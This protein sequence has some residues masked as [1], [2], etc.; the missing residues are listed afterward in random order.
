[1]SI[2]QIELPDEELKFWDEQANTRGY[3]DSADYLRSILRDLR[4]YKEYA[5]EENLTADQLAHEEKM[6]EEALASG[7]GEV[8]DDAWWDKLH[9]DVMA[10]IDAKRKQSA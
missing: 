4:R 7:E 2:L 1:M 3:A 10:N 6:M 8:T 5:V 9:A